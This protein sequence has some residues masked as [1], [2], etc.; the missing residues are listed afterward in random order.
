MW[1]HGSALRAAVAALYLAAIG[2]TQ[3]DPDDVWWDDAMGTHFCPGGQ[4]WSSTAQ[5]CTSC[6]PGK[7]SRDNS[8][9]PC[10]FC[11]QSLVPNGDQSG[12][13][14]QPLHF[15]VWKSSAGAQNELVQCTPCDSITV[16]LDT[17][18]ASQW[19]SLAHSCEDAASDTCP[20]D[21]PQCECAG[22]PKGDARICPVE[23]YWLEYQGEGE[24]F[25]PSAPLPTEHRDRAA[26]FEMIECAPPLAG[27]TSRCLHWSRCL[28]EADT[29]PEDDDPPEVE[30]AFEAGVASTFVSDR[31]Y[32]AYLALPGVER[33]Q[34]GGASVDSW[35]DTENSGPNCCLPGYRGRI[36]EYCVDGLQKIDGS[37]IKCMDV[38]SGRLV[39]GTFMALGF[40][41]WMMRKSV[42][43]FKDCH[44]TMP[45]VVFYL[46]T[47]NLMFKDRKPELVNVATN[48]FDM[49]FYKHTKA[50]CT[51]PM[52]YYAHFFFDLFASPV[53]MAV[54]YLAVMAFTYTT[55][56]AKE[57]K[58]YTSQT[59]EG[60]VRVSV[61]VKTLG[62]MQTF[63]MLS[64][65]DR[66]ILARKLSLR[67]FNAGEDILVEGDVPEQ[68]DA[69]GV[70]R[71]KGEFY[72][73]CKGEV[74]I[75]IRNLHQNDGFKQQVRTMGVGEYFGDV[76]LTQ[77]GVR[78][79]TVAALDDVACVSL[80]KQQFNELQTTFAHNAEFVQLFHKTGGDVSS[81]VEAARKKR[82]GSAL[83]YSQQW[84]S[85]DAQSDSS[86]KQGDKRTLDRVQRR[87]ALMYK[88]Q[89]DD[90]MKHR[91]QEIELRA[92]TGAC[93][94]AIGK[95]E[96]A[97]SFVYHELVGIYHACINPTA[98]RAAALEIGI[99]WYGP[100]T[101]QAMQVMFCKT[102]NEVSYPVKEPTI[103]CQ[104][105][106]HYA[107]QIFAG[108]FLF[109]VM[110]GVIGLMYYAAWRFYGVL[111]TDPRVQG[112]VLAKTLCGERWATMN[113]E[114]KR[115]EIDRCGHQLRVQLL[116]Q[117]CF[118]VSALQMTVK[119][120][121]A[122][123]YPQWHLLRR[124]LLNFA[125]MGG[126]ARG[127]KLSPM[128]GGMDWRVLVMVVL[129]ISTTIQ[130]HFRPFRDSAEVRVI[131]PLLVAVLSGKSCSVR[132]L[133]LVNG[134]GHFVPA[135]YFVTALHCTA[136]H[137]TALTALLCICGTTGAIRDVGPPVSHGYRG[138]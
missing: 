21:K 11:P 41:L 108:C 123:W 98:R 94:G 103:D 15:N 138:C 86:S 97:N 2:E 133:A 115:S 135:S 96:Q 62:K 110:F 68:A 59:V 19:K 1:R 3:Q 81:I 73:I 55:S 13:V 131:T 27:R 49:S 112:E 57:L 128:L 47:V 10:S 85:G 72:I 104:S 16:A 84:E 23:G 129:C 109:L 125:Y 5:Q 100:V 50:S 51:V 75:K 33:A 6:V 66:Q 36:C 12:C 67:Y 92:K 60:A 25:D 122:Y 107:V 48:I 93:C 22:G 89:Q 31:E 56:H 90:A 32:H 76:A 69:N 78:T 35:A 70:V 127:G 87:V 88:R 83:V 91:M 77:S 121:C 63:K 26:A 14:C 80:D 17:K 137:C 46:Q 37:C 113:K 58:T 117:E 61:A 71:D 43:P 120:D 18:D 44:G 124:T 28:S 105:N 130:Y 102:V 29:G 45:I 74:A 134:L 52:G 7:Q 53:A 111:E 8:T 30:Q 82:D 119:R 40:I 136:L 114:E 24:A 34:C 42:L 116:G 101:L 118:M 54:C 106:V 79:A 64:N 126:L 39:S 95:L 4:A 99:Y 20:Y 132:I 65:E 9:M 38:N